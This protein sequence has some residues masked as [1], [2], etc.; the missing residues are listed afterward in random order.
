MR[1]V[2][3]GTGEFAVPALQAVAKDVAL[4]VTQP[5]RPSG[6]GLSLKP[7]PVKLAAIELGLPIESPDKARATEFVLKIE[8]LNADALIVAS[9]GQILSQA[10]LETAKHG[11]INLHGSILPKYRG[12]API[13]RAILEGETETGVSLMQMDKGMDS[14]DIVA[15]DTTPIDPIETYGELQ[16][17]LAKIAAEMI[18]KW[19]PEIGTGNYPR[20]KQNHDAVSLAPKVA[21]EEAELCFE[22]DAKKEYDRFRAFNPTP[23]PYIRVQTT[24]HNPQ[25]TSLKLHKA[26]LKPE[27]GPPGTVLSLQPLP[28]IA[29]SGGSLELIEVQPEGKTRMSGRDWANGLRLQVG[30]NLKA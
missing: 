12:A 25:F 16:T 24:I 15:I 4:V 9:Y 22:R 5:D 23:G 8:E 10:L 17:R 14:G 30:Q 18:R 26:A 7:S 3:F 20:T 1:L 29:F 2:F 21:K 27:T 19:L 11:G 6:R 13:Q 28:L